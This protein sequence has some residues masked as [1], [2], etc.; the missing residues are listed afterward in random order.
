MAKTERKEEISYR[1][2]NEEKNQNL[3]KKNLLKKIK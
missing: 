2:Q 3:Q 1:R